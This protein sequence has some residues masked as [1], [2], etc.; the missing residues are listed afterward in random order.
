MEQVQSVLDIEP[1][2][3]GTFLGH[4]LKNI[5]GRFSRSQDFEYGKIFD[6][7]E[8]IKKKNLDLSIAQVMLSEVYRHPN[9][10]LESVLTTI[11]FKRVPREEILAQ[12]PYLKKKYEE[13]SSNQDEKTEVNWVMGE[14][15]SL[16]VGNI[17]LPELKSIVEK[18]MRNSQ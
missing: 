13:T 3:S 7:F 2:Y 18:N 10:D 5:E 11:N 6:L 9:M 8:F 15:R 16:A 1:R 17:S 14:L 12:I 4:R